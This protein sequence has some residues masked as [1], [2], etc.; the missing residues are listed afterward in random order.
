MI[1]RDRAEKLAQHRK[2]LKQV[3]GIGIFS[4]TAINAGFVYEALSVDGSGL[5]AIFATLIFAIFWFSAISW[6]TSFGIDLLSDTDEKTRNRTLPIWTLFMAAVM[7]LSVFMSGSFLAKGIAD[8]E[9]IHTTFSEL[10]LVTSETRQQSSEISRLETVFETVSSSAIIMKELEVNEG[11]ISGK[12]GLG[13]V[14]TLLS[15]LSDTAALS[16][17]QIVQSNASAEPIL[18]EIEE[19]QE[20]VRRILKR[21]NLAF[22]EKRELL[23][24][25]AALLSDAIV[26]L[27]RNLPVSTITN[28]I[29]SFGRDFKGSG[30]N[31]QAAQ[32]IAAVFHPVSSRLSRKLGDLKA[33][34]QLDV[35]AIE[36]LSDY[37]LLSRS[38]KALPLLVISFVL[39]SMPITLSFC[40][41][42]ISPRYES[43]SEPSNRGGTAPLRITNS[44]GS[45]DTDQVSASYLFDSKNKH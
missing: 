11:G 28:A 22:D 21:E 45:D 18:R 29:D 35:P 43:E 40:V 8:N 7:A 20:E 26:R 13:S 2:K 9:H 25:R 34:T 17:K 32:R 3:A 33:A 6:A 31:D 37:E 36:N 41:F 16:R 44:E 39:A 27:Q 38:E 15:S 19:T 10:N 42:L 1:T 4:D 14:A 12:S 23:S 5:V 30:I 24:S